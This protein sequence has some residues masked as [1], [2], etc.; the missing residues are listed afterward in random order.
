M[1]TDNR[2]ENRKYGSWKPQKQWTQYLAQAV[3]LFLEIF[4]LRP[5]EICSV[6]GS[7]EGECNYEAVPLNICNTWKSKNISKIIPAWRK[8]K[9]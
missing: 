4:S 3:A 5:P 2:I 1:R 6:S 7:Y 8:L 9:F